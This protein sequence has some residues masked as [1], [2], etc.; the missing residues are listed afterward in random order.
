MAGVKLLTPCPLLQRLFNQQLLLTIPSLVLILI[1]QTP[2]VN[3]VVPEQPVV[4]KLKAKERM[5][6][7]RRKDMVQGCD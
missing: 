5:K 3:S 4:G 7:M 1:L 2:N 6:I